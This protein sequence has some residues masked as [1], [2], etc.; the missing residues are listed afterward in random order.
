MKWKFEI[1]NIVFVCSRSGAGT[2]K[3]HFYQNLTR[4]RCRTLQSSY[5]LRECIYIP[6]VEAR[7][8]LCPQAIQFSLNLIRTKICYLKINNKVAIFTIHLVLIIMY[9]LLLSLREVLINDCI[10]LVF[11]FS[12]SVKTLDVSRWQHM[13]VNSWWQ[14]KKNVCLSLSILPRGCGK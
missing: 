1:L 11:P 13:K 2:S 10:F 9:L 7:P 8:G 14:S 6:G 3:R 12:L 5:W 4:T